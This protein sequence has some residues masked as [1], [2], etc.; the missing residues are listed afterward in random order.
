[1]NDYVLGFSIVTNTKRRHGVL[2]QFN[3]QKTNE[4]N[5]KY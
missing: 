2:L 5:A 4:N 1:M 3:I